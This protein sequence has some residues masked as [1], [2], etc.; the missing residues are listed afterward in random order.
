MIISIPYIGRF[1]V[2]RG[3]K[4]FFVLT[5]FSLPLLIGNRNKFENNKDSLL[6]QQASLKFYAARI[7]I[8]SEKI[9][10]LR[11]SGIIESMKTVLTTPLNS[12]LEIVDETQA[13]LIVDHA[14]LYAFLY[15]DVLSSPDY[16]SNHDDSVSE[17]EIRKSDGSKTSLKRQIRLKNWWR[18]RR[19]RRARILH[20]NRMKK[21]FRVD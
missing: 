13:L 15:L 7:G 14:E 4:T 6:A 16:E 19:Q 3:M 11:K 1:P 9:K 17:K 10:N 5:F 8:S 20:L 21:I 12:F 2:L 18:K